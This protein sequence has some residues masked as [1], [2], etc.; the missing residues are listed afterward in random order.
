MA[1][2][3]TSLA[4]PLLPADAAPVA[5][6]ERLIDQA[7]VVLY[8]TVG[9]RKTVPS[10]LG[11]EG[12]PVDTLVTVAVS[13][14]IKGGPGRAVTVRVPGGV[15]ADGTILSRASDEPLITGDNVLLYLGPA[16][17]GGAR[18]VVEADDGTD[19][20]GVVP[21]KRRMP[22][23][24][25][26]NARFD[27]DPETAVLHEACDD[28]PDDQPQEGYS[29]IVPR[30]N[31]YGNHIVW[32]Q[33]ATTM[34]YNSNFAT[35]VT[36]LNTALG[37]WNNQGDGTHNWQLGTSTAAAATT[38]TDNT[39]TTGWG[40]NATSTRLGEAWMRSYSNGALIE[41]D[42]VMNQARQTE[43][44][45]NPTSAQYDIIHVLMHEVGHG[46]GFAHQINSQS[47]MATCSLGKGDN[48]RRTLWAG[49]EAGHTNFYPPDT[50]GYYLVKEDGAVFGH[51]GMGS[52]GQYNA[53]HRGGANENNVIN[54]PTFRVTDMETA[55]RTRDGYHILASNGGVFAF[56]TARFLGS[57][58]GNITGTAVDMA[59]HPTG[60]YYWVL[61]SDGGVF[62]FPSPGGL[63]Y[64]SGVG[65]MN[66]PAVGIEETA[67]GGGYWLVS[68]K[69]NVYSRGNAHFYGGGIPSW[70]WP[71][72]GIE[73]SQGGGGYWVIGNDGTLYAFG[74]APARYMG[75][76][77]A[78]ARK[79]SR[80]PFSNGV[81]TVSNAGYTRV[82]G[83]TDY[84]WG[85]QASPPFAAVAATRRPTAANMTFSASPTALNV[86]RGQTATSTMTISSNESFYA[87][88]TFSVSGV[89]SG[90]SAYVS[91]NP[92]TLPSSATRTSTLYV[93]P[94]STYTA[95]LNFTLTVNACGQGICRSQQ[96]SVVVALV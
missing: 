48:T 38:H 78:S 17:A 25:E 16:D 41:V 79:V 56:G 28:D 73:R 33:A 23:G 58:A 46:L 68:D 63:F 88:V 74:D 36:S 52:F 96:V 30:N 82:N 11:L 22:H 2:A 5:S 13:R 21:E 84:G 80:D 9:E 14:P 92:V 10:E 7:D 75:A 43:L 91:P 95:P 24:E 67:D 35:Q 8:G 54:Y 77:N 15:L 83:I 18:P 12:V 60:D 47:I 65:I 70:N 34:N 50:Q 20:A 39:N 62:A 19:E 53:P 49:E 86:R 51:G 81:V 64:D 87:T 94:S 4:T 90:V 69:G 61:A 45:A 89:P 40:P 31:A 71:A 72:R 44:S 3:I 6:G 29:G 27:G 66:G 42:V 32:T 26:R 76:A 85:T 93:T 1:V 57:A 37:N 55:R 59:V